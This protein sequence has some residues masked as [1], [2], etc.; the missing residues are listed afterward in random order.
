MLGIGDTAQSG[1]GGVLAHAG[2]APSQTPADVFGNVFFVFLLLG[3]LVGIVVIGYTMYN[4]FKYR[5]GGGNGGGDEGIERPEVGELPTGGGG[6]KKLFLSFGISALIVLSLI[7]WTY[8]LLMFV[9][10]GQAGT[11]NELEVDVIGSKF[12]WQFVYPNGETTS[13]LRVPTD[14]RIQLNVNSTDVFHNFGIPS[15]GVKTDAIPGQQTS[16]WFVA[17]N[18]GSYMAHCYELCGQGHSG[19]DAEVRAL[20]PGAFQDWYA[21]TGA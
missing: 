13:T 10:E 12:S 9:E 19:M 3:T 8:G 6:G 1:L 2:G 16:T 18:T 21:S 11:A 7:V 4:A 17:E 15:M 14:R 5:D 20:T